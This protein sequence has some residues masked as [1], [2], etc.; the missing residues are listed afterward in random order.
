MLIKFINLRS[1]GAELLRESH[2]YMRSR[3]VAI[4]FLYQL[5]VCKGLTLEQVSHTL[6][7]VTNLSLE[8]SAY[9]DKTKHLLL[10]VI[11]RVSFN[12]LRSSDAIYLW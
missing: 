4:L 10:L 1:H 8:T 9:C 3:L 2:S 7:P 12:S 5:P 6:D 11:L